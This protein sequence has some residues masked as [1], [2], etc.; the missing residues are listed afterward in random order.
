[1]TASITAYS[2]ISSPSSCNHIWRSSSFIA[3]PCL[4]KVRRPLRLRGGERGR[5][6]SADPTLKARAVPSRGIA[7]TFRYQS[8]TAGQLKR[9]MKTFAH[10]RRAL[11]LFLI[12]PGESG[13]PDGKRGLAQNL[14]F[15]RIAE[16]QSTKVVQ[17]LFHIRDT[18]ARPVGAKQRFGRDFFQA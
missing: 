17:V 14:L 1:M 15:Y 11:S 2:A 18:W 16:R 9:Q 13:G 6:G 7:K 12:W 4:C 5:G 3:P 10:T 8:L